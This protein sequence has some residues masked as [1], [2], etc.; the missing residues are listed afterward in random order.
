MSKLMYKYTHSHLS[1]RSGIFYFVRRILVDV[2]KHYKADRNSLSLRTRVISKAVRAAQSINQRLE[3]YWLV[4]RLQQIDIPAINLVRESPAESQP[5]INLSEA[6]DLYLK[7]KGP[8]RDK[9]F[10]M[11]AHRNIGYVI[12]VL[13]NNS[14]TAY[15]STDAAKFRDWLI[16]RGM[17]KNTVSR[18]FSTVRAV[19]NLAIKEHGLSGLNGFAGTFMPDGL[20][21][22]KRKPIPGNTIEY[23]Q[24]KCLE[25][26]D[27][28]RWLVALLS[29]TGMRLGEAIGLL[30]SDIILTGDIPYIDLK[31]YAWR[32][33][34]TTGSQRKIPLVGI[35]LWA[36]QAIVNQPSQSPFAFPRYCSEQGHKT[37][38]ASAALN[39]WLKNQSSQDA[40]VH[41]F[42]HSI[43][44]RLREVECPF[45][46]IDQLGGW[47]TNGVG[48][49]YGFGYSLEAMNRWMKR[50]SKFGHHQSTQSNMNA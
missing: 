5:S 34:K 28:R 46:L 2:R 23:I 42:R 29:D 20:R 8:G 37:N 48:N 33:L 25:A 18:I 17:A 47:V 43:R 50:I 45:D 15:S 36:A 24:Q 4:L 9:T 16:D 40:V 41:S 12:K 39:K 38:S 19:I 44:D 35:A 27:D 31:P 6:R 22:K 32:R 30:K 21:V 7:L 13:G 10:F 1:V 26:N 3:D 14:V 49:S 11:G